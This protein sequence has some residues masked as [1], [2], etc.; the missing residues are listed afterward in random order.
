MV[1]PTFQDGG[2]CDPLAGGIGD[3]QQIQ[4][5]VEGKFGVDPIFVQASGDLEKA[6]LGEVLPESLPR[7]WWARLP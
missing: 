2:C 5:P 7:R 6:N 3:D 4:R 1:D